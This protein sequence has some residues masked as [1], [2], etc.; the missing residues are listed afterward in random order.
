MPWG[1]DEEDP[2]VEVP[3]L[4]NKAIISRRGPYGHY[5]IRLAKGITPREFE[6]TWT[7]LESATKQIKLLEN[8]RN[9]EKEKTNATASV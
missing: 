4:S 3:Y 2:D 1:V 5:V 6:G 8:R 9:T 7:T